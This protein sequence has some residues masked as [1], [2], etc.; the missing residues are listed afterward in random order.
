[1]N[2]ISLAEEAT[3]LQTMNLKFIN[4]KGVNIIQL[5]NIINFLLFV[6]INSHILLFL[7]Q[8]CFLI[9][10][11]YANIKIIIKI[12]VLLNNYFY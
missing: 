8:F 12:K 7:I 5:K 2:T 6:R 4:I 3:S 10:Y 1:M 9:S 11:K